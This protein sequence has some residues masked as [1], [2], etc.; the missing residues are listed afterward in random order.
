[1]SFADP[2]WLILLIPLGLAVWQWRLPSRL[3]RALRGAALLAVLLALAGLHVRLPLRSGTV[4]LVADQSL[5]MP[6]G[7]QEV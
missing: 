2:F 1:M 5:S 7:S 4:I 3:L 6:P